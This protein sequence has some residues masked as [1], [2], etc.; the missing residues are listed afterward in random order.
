MRNVLTG[1]DLFSPIEPFAEG[2]LDVG[3]G[4][5]IYW[6]VSGNPAGIPVVFV[7]GGPGA[8]TQPA[9]RRFFDPRIWKIVLFDQ[10]GCG[11]SRPLASIAHN[12]TQHLIADMEAIRAMLK[13]DKWLLFGG[14]W[15]STLALAYGEA[16][17]QRTLGFVLRGVFL[18]RP[19]EV[20]W[21]LNGMGHFFPE[22][23][24]RFRDFLPEAE[25][26]ALL[27]SYYARLTADDPAVHMPAARVWC[28]YEEGCARLVPRGTFN[29]M[30]A[31]GNLAMARVECHYM[32]NDGFFRPNQLLDEL[33]RIHSLPCTIVQ[34]RYDVICPPK[35]ADELA[36]SW[37][38]SR[39]IV[40]PEAGHSAL[41]P[42]T[43]QALV[44]AVEDMRALLG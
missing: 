34:G 4:H 23:W 38:R 28:A 1:P 27:A 12:T 11:N 17:P 10:R 39:L 26:G 18:F 16:Y 37:P 6:E 22:T 29:D 21:F 9:F 19:W 14:S 44:G 8:G 24:T 7:H 25:R 2:M 33:A 13:I 20:E 43:R 35:T 41:E 5:S 3:D 32:V 40:I 31:R 15:G 42:G 30:A 36:R